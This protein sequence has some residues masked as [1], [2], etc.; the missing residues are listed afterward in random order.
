MVRTLEAR[1]L[2]ATMAMACFARASFATGG[3][4]AANAT[5]CTGVGVCYCVNS[6]FRSAIAEK[7]DTYRELIAAERAKG[8]AI[9]Y[10]SI[11]H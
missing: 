8:K 9:G 11:P 3:A 10:M 1:S 5:E 6:D 2:A 4:N 7:V